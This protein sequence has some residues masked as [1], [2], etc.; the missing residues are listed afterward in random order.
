[1]LIRHPYRNM[2]CVFRLLFVLSSLTSA[3]AQESRVPLYELPDFEARTR[4]RI[5]PDN[6]DLELLADCIIYHTNAAR[7]AG[8]LG[9]CSPDRQL[10]A[11]ASAHS[12]EMATLNYFSH[13]S[14]VRKNLTLDHRLKNAGIF[15]PGTT[16]GEN[17]GV[18]FILAL[19]EVP[20]YTET[21]RGR[22]Y[23]YNW[24]TKEKIKAQTYRQFARNMVKNWLASPGHRENLLEPRFNKIGIGV[25]AGRYRGHAAL[26]VTQNF[27]G[28]LASGTTSGTAHHTHLQRQERP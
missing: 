2:Q 19:S 12:L 21:H 24:Q 22:T 13:E 4:N 11:V 9:E 7:R 16:F 6:I 28:P 5:D 1:M 20:Y 8:A 3:A 26:Y 15:L 27:Q 23:Y 14:P 18:D 10:T 25:A 17:L